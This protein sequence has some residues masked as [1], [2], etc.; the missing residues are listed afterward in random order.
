MNNK[1]ALPPIQAAKQAVGFSRYFSTT[2]CLVQTFCY[3]P[4]LCL[5]NQMIIQDCY[6][7][8]NG[9]QREACVSAPFSQ[10]EGPLN[11]TNP[12]HSL[13]SGE[14]DLGHAQISV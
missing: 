7:G 12:L 14:K 11:P 2:L 13:L 6:K 10:S 9:Y 5:Q 3:S 8:K 1:P 4:F